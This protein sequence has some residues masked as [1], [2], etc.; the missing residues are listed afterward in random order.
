MKKREDETAEEFV[1]RR[2]QT[3]VL[4]QEKLAKSANKKKNKAV[5]RPRPKPETIFVKNWVSDN[6]YTPD[7]HT[8]KRSR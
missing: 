2:R 1:K 8:T 6:K 4:L 3:W 5:R 7:K